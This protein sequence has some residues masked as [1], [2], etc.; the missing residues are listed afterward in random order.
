MY[1]IICQSRHH[2]TLDESCSKRL[3]NSLKN[4]TPFQGKYDVLSNFYP[5]PL[6]FYGRLF[7][8]AEHA[9]QFLKAKCYGKD[10]LAENISQQSSAVFAKLLA[11]RVPTDEGWDHLKVDVMR[12]ILL[13]KKQCVPEY[14]QKLLEVADTIIVEAVPGE[15]FWSSGLSKEQVIWAD[16]WPGKNIMGQLHMELTEKSIKE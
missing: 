7:K 6:I 1:C 8:S 13:A 11:K 9:Y 5:C 14:R 2:K 15:T 16:E 3:Q 12:D 4:V 10:Q